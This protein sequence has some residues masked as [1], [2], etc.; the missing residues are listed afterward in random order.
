MA[1]LRLNPI[2]A[3]GSSWTN[4]NNIFDGSTTTLTSV[5]VKNSSYSSRALTVVFDTT[6]IPKNVIINSSI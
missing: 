5:K 6:L 2:S 3:S 4:I 1:T